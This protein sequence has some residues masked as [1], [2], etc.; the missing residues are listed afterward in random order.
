[1][2]AINLEFDHVFIL[3]NKDANE[4]EIFKKHGFTPAVVG[5]HDGQGTAAK[6]IFFLNMLIE[7]LYIDDE[8]EAKNN[9]NAFGCNYIDRSNWKENGQNP[10]GI[11]ITPKPYN[12]K[13]IP[14]ETLYYVPKWLPRE[15]M[16]M[17]LSNIDS[18]EPIIFCEPPYMEFPNFE[19]FNDLENSGRN[20]IKDFFYHKNGIV[21]MTKFRMIVNT[22]NLSSTL[23]ELNKHNM[24]IIS[25]NENLME[26]SFDNNNKNMKI[27]FRPDLPLIIYY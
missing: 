19:N 20:D 9:I 4:L 21:K 14:F 22:D 11:G 27:D 25:G 1:M 8:L 2:N 7:L 18:R 16:Q 10:F 5:K 12:Y 17:A 6:F 15:G 3:V 26:L 23:L 13:I 24:E